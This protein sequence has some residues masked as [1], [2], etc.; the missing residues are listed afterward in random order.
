MVE[1]ERR[2]N[3]VDRPSLTIV[4]PCLNSAPT[5]PTALE[6][7]RSQQYGGQVEHLVVDGGSTDGTLEILE[8]APGV[9]YVSEPDRGLSDAVNKGIRMGQGEIVGWLNADDVYLPGA[10][11]AVGR[12]FADAPDALWAT[13]PCLIMDESG[14]E[15]RKAVTAYKSFFLRH[16]SYSLQVEINSG[17]RHVVS[18]MAP[19]KPGRRS[20][21]SPSPSDAK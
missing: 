4:T 20:V 21:R 18:V 10:F 8:A 15:I 1:G 6:S 17:E 19:T 9:T 11:E 13:G 2:V 5:L 7:V 12:A 3:A 14:N 16:Y